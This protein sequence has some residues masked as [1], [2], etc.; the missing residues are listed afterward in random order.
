MDPLS[1]GLLGASFTQSATASVSVKKKK[2][3][4]QITLIGTLSGMAPDL[5]VL[6]F[7]LEDPLFSLIYH[8][9]FTHSL[10]FAPIGAFFLCFLFSKFFKSF[11]FKEIYYYSFLGIITHGFLDSC[12][13]YGTL[14]FWPFSEQRI[15]WNVIPIVDLLFTLPLLFFVVL[16]VRKNNP[17]IARIGFI[18]SLLVLFFGWTQK[19]R[20]EKALLEEVYTR[21]HSPP[22]IYAKPFFFHLFKWRTIYE[23]RGHFFVQGVKVIPY[24][25]PFFYKLKL[26]KK[27]N[28]SQHLKE[29]KPSDKQ[30]KDVQK[31]LWFTQNF[32]GYDP[33]NPHVLGDLRYSPFP[34]GTKS[35]WGIKVDPTRPQSHIKRI[36]L[37]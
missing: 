37:R 31:Y 10:F 29:L 12:T 18:V 20:V 34:S 19:L 36:S 26:I 1:Q 22:Y 30:H 28:I 17:F 32:I 15:S 3:F 4:L 33:K 8:R 25:K 2:K 13:S 21:A 5:D 14:L 27:F 24:K 23:H 6:I 7:S 11:S 9:H 35:L 16:S